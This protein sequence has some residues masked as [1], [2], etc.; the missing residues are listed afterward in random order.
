MKDKIFF[1][2]TFIIALGIIAAAFYPRFINSEIAVIGAPKDGAIILSTAELNQ[3][4]GD[5]NTKVTPAPGPTGMQFGPRMASEQINDSRH[6][7]SLHF[8][9]SLSQKLSG[10]DL[11]ITAKIAPLKT[12]PAQTM[13][14]GLYFQ[15]GVIVE[16]S[17]V[18]KDPTF[19]R[20][21][22]SAQNSAPK[23][24]VIIPALE[25]EAHGIEVQAI[26]IEAL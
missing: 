3:F 7:A 22:F 24:I 11:I 19:I 14:L 10:K 8:A 18:H 20:F 5:E 26:K 1:P 15:N 9:Q 6:G 17:I 4:K 23:G 16:K 12:T 13:E 25:G 21:R 2:F